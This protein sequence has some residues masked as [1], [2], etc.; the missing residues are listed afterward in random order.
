MDYASAMSKLI[1]LR[2]KADKKGTISA[3]ISIELKERLLNFVENNDLYLSSV[4]ERALEKYLDLM[5]GK[6]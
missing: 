1:K 6:K 2:S 5:S 4:V 3:S